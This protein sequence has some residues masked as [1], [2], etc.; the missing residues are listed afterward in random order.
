MTGKQKVLSVLGDGHWHSYR[1]LFDVYF[2]YTAR[3]YELRKDGYV[4]EERVNR[5][6]KHAFDYRLVSKPHAYQRS[7]GD[8]V[9]IP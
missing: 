5:F 8:L 3:I 6:N 4:F 9:T 7:F 1:E 2:K